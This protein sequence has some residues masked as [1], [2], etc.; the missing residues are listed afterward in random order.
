MR[1]KKEF[2]VTDDLLASGG[3]RFINYIVDVI[4]LYITY[5]LAPLFFLLF[6]AGFPSEILDVESR[7]RILQTLENIYIYVNIF[8]LNNIT[9]KQLCAVF[10]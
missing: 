10:C 3:Q 5:I 6:N 2:E 4:V 1:S 7:K 8:Y 9:I